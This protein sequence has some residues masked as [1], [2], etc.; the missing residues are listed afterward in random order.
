MMIC[1]ICVCVCMRVCMRI[2]FF[3]VYVKNKCDP[4]INF[5][6][7]IFSQ[8]NVYF[9]PL[10]VKILFVADANFVSFIPV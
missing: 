3:L 5:Y 7:A 1:S 9:I 2:F 6:R 8:S 4:Y 10:F